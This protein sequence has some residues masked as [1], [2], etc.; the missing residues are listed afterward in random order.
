MASRII[1]Q[2]IF[3]YIYILLL[4][5]LYVYA[6]YIY[7]YIYIYMHVFTFIPTVSTASR[8]AIVPL[9]KHIWAR[10]PQFW[11]SLAVKMCGS[12]ALGRYLSLERSD[13]PYLEGTFESMI[14][15]TSRLV[16]YGIC[17]LQFPAR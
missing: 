11:G 17:Y 9:G 12:K 4:V 5:H 7:T 13:I 10:H 1:G 16:G 14:F 8:F 6:P 3:D 2:F 15:R